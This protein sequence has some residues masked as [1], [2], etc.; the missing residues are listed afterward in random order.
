MKNISAV[1][2]VIAIL[3]LSFID[4]KPQSDGSAHCPKLNMIE[5]LEK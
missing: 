1:I 5:E 3:S 2:F 4:G